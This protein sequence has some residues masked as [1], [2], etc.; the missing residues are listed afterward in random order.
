MAL[1]TLPNTDDGKGHFACSLDYY[2]GGLDSLAHAQALADK[3]DIVV[4]EADLTG[5]N[6]FGS[7]GDDMV[8]RNADILLM[9]YGRTAES[10]TSSFPA[11]YYA[12]TR[13]G[14]QISAGSS[15]KVMQP[16]AA[17]V[18][19]DPRGFAAASWDDW[20]G[21]DALRINSDYNA[22]YGANSLRGIYLD[23]A[24]ATTFKATQVKP[25]T[26]TPYSKAEWIDKVRSVGDTA[27]ALDAN[28]WV[29][30]NMLLSGGAYLLG[31][32]PT[33]D[34]L[35]HFLGGVAEGFLR[36]N[37]D[38]ATAFPDDTA[39]GKAIDMMI[40]AQVS[41]SKRIWV[42]TQIGNSATGTAPAGWA[43]F[44]ASEQD[45]W[46]RFGYVAYLIGNRGKAWFEFVKEVAE[47]PWDETHAYYSIDL[48]APLDTA[49]TWA[50]TK[51]GNVGKR[52]YTNGVAYLTATGGSITAD[53][54][55]VDPVSGAV[56]D[57]AAT[58]TLPPNT[59]LILTLAPAPPVGNA[60]APA[61]AILGP[62]GTVTPPTTALGR[63]TVTDADGISSVTM[64]IDGDPVVTPALAL[65][66]YSHD[67]G[68]LSPGDHALTVTAID[69]FADPTKRRTSTK[70]QIFTVAVPPPASGAGPGADSATILISTDVAE[71]T[72]KLRF[73]SLS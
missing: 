38:N 24:H 58:V 64:R 49:A 57:I 48:G 2:G 69:N 43:N 12:L 9:S 1:L 37:F 27:I 53:R 30:A 68:G 29:W 17:G 25:G 35:S 32:P 3:C 51:T 14:S 40:D 46:K 26:S 18:Y 22:T 42:K 52:R 4:G 61:I 13:S 55:Y 6:D 73:R 60:D 72:L 50:A 71:I 54:G 41:L 65:G 44:T 70:T 20:R 15:R 28:T 33:R 19:N 47:K 45:Q 11:A 62:S 63:A 10:A 31:E 67:F 7:W 34:G 8:A 39:L 59:G 23:A 5:T 36:G 56:Y 16:G 66:V 21:R